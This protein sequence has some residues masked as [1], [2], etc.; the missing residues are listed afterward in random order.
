M[1]CDNQHECMPALPARMGL[2]A[3]TSEFSHPLE[4]HLRNTAMAAGF[5]TAVIQ[6]NRSAFP[7]NDRPLTVLPFSSCLPNL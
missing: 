1:N 5:R 6:Q 7:I 2:C 3:P 4:K